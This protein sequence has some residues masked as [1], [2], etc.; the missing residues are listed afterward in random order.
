MMTTAAAILSI[1][2]NKNMVNMKWIQN[3]LTVL[4]LCVSLC[5]L[6]LAMAWVADLFTGNS[7]KPSEEARFVAMYDKG[8]QMVQG[9]YQLP[10]GWQLRQKVATDPHTMVSSQFD[11]TFSGPEDARVHVLHPSP[12]LQ[13]PAGSDSAR[14]KQN[15]HAYSRKYNL[16]WYQDYRQAAR[17]LLDS[18][19]DETSAGEWERVE[20]NCL[21]EQ[22]RVKGNREGRALEVL[23]CVPQGPA[24]VC[25]WPQKLQNYL[26]VAPEGQLENALAGLRQLQGSFVPNQAFLYYAWQHNQLQDTRSYNTEPLAD[27]VQVWYNGNYY[28][29]GLS[30][31]DAR[32]YKSTAANWKKM[33]EWKN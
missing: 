7:T 24:R 33:E 30:A 25:Q 22:L 18:L 15:T 1:G 16:Y 27:R 28:S 21:R 17:Q 10:P 6:M 14:V 11:M 23:V 4:Q 8:L 29:Q 9:Y 32:S 19:F 2:K 13:V 31:S 5:L 12:Y 3:L 26:V 20:G